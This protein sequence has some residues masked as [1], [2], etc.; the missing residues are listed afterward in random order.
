MSGKGWKLSYFQVE[1]ESSQKGMIS[2]QSPNFQGY[3]KTCDLLS[4]NQF[5]CI[6]LISHQTE[7]ILR[8]FVYLCI[9]RTNTIIQAKNA[10]RKFKEEKEGGWHIGSILMSQRPWLWKEKYTTKRIVFQS[11]H[12][13]QDLLCVFLAILDNTIRKTASHKNNFLQLPVWLFPSQLEQKNNKYYGE[14]IL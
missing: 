3:Y 14:K 13:L 10:I 12:F 9:Q 2:K 11:L 7:F 5:K 8:W 4:P 1:D 6:K